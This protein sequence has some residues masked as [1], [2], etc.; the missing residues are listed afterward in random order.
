MVACFLR[1]IANQRMR[2]RTAKR[3]SLA[4]SVKIDHVAIV[5]R[6]CGNA[7]MRHAKYTDDIRHSGLILTT[8]VM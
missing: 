2:K 5:I 7:K 4:R 1:A 8:H 6:E 3:L